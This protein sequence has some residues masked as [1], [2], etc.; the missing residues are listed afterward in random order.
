MMIQAALLYWRIWSDQ[1]FVPGELWLIYPNILTYDW[2]IQ[3]ETNFWHV[4]LKHVS[5]LVYTTYD[6]YFILLQ[7]EYQRE[8]ERWWGTNQRVQTRVR[9]R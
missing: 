2:L 1:E 5:W 8:P 6:L 4:D 9:S 3:T 7:E